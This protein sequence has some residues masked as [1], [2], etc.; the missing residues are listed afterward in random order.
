ME[1]WLT[2]RFRGAPLGLR[3]RFPPEL[4]FLARQLR[5]LDG[6]EVPPNER[7]S[8][9]Y[10]ELTPE[11]AEAVVAWGR[12]R[13]VDGRTLLASATYEERWRAQELAGAAAV[14]L[15]RGPTVGAPPLLGR[16]RSHLAHWGCSYCDR[17]RWEQVGPLE[18]A[19]DEPA[20]VEVLHRARPE[21][22]LTEAG[23]LVVSSRLRSVLEAHGLAIRPVV[24]TRSW[25]QVD[26]QATVRL[27]SVPPLEGMGRPC[28]GCALQRLGRREGPEERNDV[29]IV[30]TTSWTLVEP[31]PA[32]VSL[33]WSEQRLG[34]SGV[35]HDGPVHPMGAPIDL[36]LHPGLFGEQGA[37]VLVASAELACALADAHAVGLEVRPV[38]CLAAGRREVAPHAASC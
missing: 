19:L 30:R 24:G 18:L 21:V 29:R 6:P 20:D 27:A 22:L 38:R 32:G 28:R 36:D 31:L 4:A 5:S 10:V 23:E 2:L 7:I 16:S 3:D 34:F 25:L 1:L 12:M 17:L 26:V 11:Q 35:V 37:P 14:E 33:A 8:T 13:G 9:A 15:G